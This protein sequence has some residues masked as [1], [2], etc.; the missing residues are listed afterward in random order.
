MAFTNFDTKEINCKIIYF[1]PRGAGKT[2]NLRSIYKNT[3]KEARSGLIELEESRAGTKFFD[4]LPV[5][6]GHVKDFHLKLHLFTLPTNPLY[7][8]VNS[9][10]LKGVDGIVFVADSRVELM[11]ENIQGL[12]ETRRLLADQGYN[13]S[14]LP[15]VIQYNKRD[16]Q[17]LVP[18]DV[19]RHELNPSNL[20]DQ[21]AVARDSMGTMETL[22][23]MSKLVLKKIAP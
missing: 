2:E 7:E 3:A 17:D 9:V 1:G 23:A 16:L 8:S 14:D 13:F 18:L 19:L 10:I 20:T 5:S 11:A 22:Q 6:M 21:K 15:R 4:F 12:A